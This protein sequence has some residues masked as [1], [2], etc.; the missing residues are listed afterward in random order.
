M[1]Q[2][3]TQLFDLGPG[4]TWWGLATHN[5]T[6]YALQ[7]DGN[8]YS[9]D[10]VAQT[11]TQLFD[12]GPGTW[13]ALATHNGTLYAMQNEGNIYSVDLVAQTA[14]QLF[15]LGASTW[16]GLTT[17]TSASQSAR[18]SDYFIAEKPSNT[19]LRIIPVRN[20]YVHEIVGI[21]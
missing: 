10:L 8:I 13:Y 18:V 19:S 3:A 21:L 17:H 7:S 1:A 20:G 14:T 11:A 9:V 6:L 15:D 5:G 16:W 4:T 12:L 2:T